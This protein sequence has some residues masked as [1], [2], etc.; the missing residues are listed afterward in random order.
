MDWISPKYCV[1]LMFED[2]MARR[3]TEC[4]YILS[5]RLRQA[6]ASHGRGGGGTSIGQLNVQC[7]DRVLP[8]SILKL[9]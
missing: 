7:G 2:Q 8:E 3:C 9:P 5:N 4:Q 6:A 1:K